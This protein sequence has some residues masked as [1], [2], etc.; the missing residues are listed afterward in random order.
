MIIA[1]AASTVS[2]LGISHAAVS[3]GASAAAA[4]NLDARILRPL[5]SRGKGSP[6][7]V[8]VRGEQLTDP[9]FLSTNV[10]LSAALTA[11]D[12]A[13]AYADAATGMVVM[14]TVLA[15]RIAVAAVSVA[16]AVD[17]APVVP[18]TIAGITLGPFT[19]VV[20]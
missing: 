14:A 12:L 2:R 16:L 11:D 6:A 9:L 17:P 19:E 7:A 3:L 4:A 13:H 5:D 18:F 10:L 8:S 20:P 1:S 15:E